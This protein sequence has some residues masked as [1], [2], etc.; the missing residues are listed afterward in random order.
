MV[1]FKSSQ[2]I[3]ISSQGRSQL[4]QSPGSPGKVCLDGQDLDREGAGDRVPGEGSGMN[5]D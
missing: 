4:A 1:F 5:R 2:A 3:L